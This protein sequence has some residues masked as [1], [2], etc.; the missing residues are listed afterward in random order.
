MSTNLIVILLLS[1]GA[2]VGLGLVLGY[3]AGCEMTS[4]R[5]YAAYFNGVRAGTQEAMR[6]W[7]ELRAS[8]ESLGAGGVQ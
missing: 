8:D 2:C 3:W 7:Q 1:W 6:Q 5:E 4:A